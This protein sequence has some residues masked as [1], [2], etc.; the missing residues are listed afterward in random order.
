[1]QKI[2]ETCDQKYIIP[3]VIDPTHL[4]LQMRMG[5]DAEED[6][7]IYQLSW[8]EGEDNCEVK[9]Y[10]AEFMPEQDKAEFVTDNQMILRFIKRYIENNGLWI[11]GLYKITLDKVIKE[12][13]G[14]YYYLPMNYWKHIFQ[15]RE[16]FVSTHP[17]Y[18]PRWESDYSNWKLS[19]IKS[20][21]TSFRKYNNNWDLYRFYNISVKYE[22]YSSKSNYNHEIR[23]HIDPVT[24][25]PRYV[26]F[27]NNVIN[28]DEDY[29]YLALN[30]DFYLS[31]IEFYT[32][33]ILT[34]LDLITGTDDIYS[35][36]MDQLTNSK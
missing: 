25:K 22:K 13:D 17:I 8:K 19:I 24:L 1:M 6:N 3:N 35:V 27:F 28:R 23:F 10:K 15:D 16:Y 2:I 36:N 7:M 21:N 30:V 31:E 4:Q 14:Y 5:N 12:F 20:D 33:P 32:E 9:T 18:H 34:K 11:D 26:Y 29:E